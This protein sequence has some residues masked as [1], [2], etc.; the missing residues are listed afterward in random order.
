M[1]QDFSR[2]GVLAATAGLAATAPA[3]LA[4]AAQA[5]AKVPTLLN[6]SYD[7][8][9]E[10]YKQID[11]AYVKYWKDKTGQEIQICGGASLPR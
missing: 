10:L 9:R 1:S 8:T 6:V 7:P 2:R 4:G 5:A 11:A 3:L